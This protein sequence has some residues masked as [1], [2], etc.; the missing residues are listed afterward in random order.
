VALF[1][2]L[3]ES[4]AITAGKSEIRELLGIAEEPVVGFWDFGLQLGSFGSPQDSDTSAEQ[5]RSQNP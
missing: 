1:S 2:P 5:R 4:A 3:G